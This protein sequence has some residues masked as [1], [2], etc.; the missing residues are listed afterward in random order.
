MPT[1]HAPLSFSVP[2]VKNTA[3]HPPLVCSALGLV[4]DLVGRMCAVEAA[5]A[6]GSVPAAAGKEA[7][8]TSLPLYR[9]QA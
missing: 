4:A 2:W 3:V 6:M 1:L 9:E 7:V 5:A 8:G